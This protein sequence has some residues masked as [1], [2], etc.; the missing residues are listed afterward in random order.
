MEYMLM[1]E[2]TVLIMLATLPVIIITSLWCTIFGN[3][4]PIKPG[5]VAFALAILCTLWAQRLGNMDSGMALFIILLFF[6]A[7]PVVFFLLLL[8]S[9][10]RK[11]PASALSGAV[12][13]LCVIIALLGGAN[14]WR[15]LGF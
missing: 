13:G 10:L 7:S 15:L 2:S 5:I 9:W 14:L 1:D 11:G 12:R 6:T 4:R 8:R 3:T